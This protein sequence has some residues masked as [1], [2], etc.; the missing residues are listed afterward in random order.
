M[1]L[2]PKKIKNKHYTPC[3]SNN[4]NP[5]ICKDKDLMYVNAECGMCI[6]CR[7]KKQREWTARLCEEIRYNK[8]L[9][10]TLTFDNIHLRELGIKSNN[11]NEIAKRAIRLFL[12]RIRK[13]TKKSIKHW[14]ITELGDE[15]ERIHIHG[16]TWCEES[17]IKDNWNYGYVYIGQFVNEKTIRY[18]TKYML[19]I[20][21]T[22]KDFIPKI[23]C[24]S[25]IGKNY[26]DRL[27]ARNNEF[28]EKDT[29][30]TYRLK[31]GSKIYLPQYYRRKIYTAEERE[32]LWKQKIEK[33]ISYIM[34]EKVKSNTDEETQLRMY[35]R[36]KA[37]KLYKENWEEWE[38]KKKFRQRMKYKK[39]K[40][41]NN[42]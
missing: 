16:I 19:K 36:E 12:E 10:V 24:S 7:R 35:Y 5:P 33:G 3:K 40:D 38:R 30:E 14:F 20:K 15:T 23:M 25:G 26:I 31:N 42:T 9:F 11:D 6:E 37:K 28:K 34:G 2:Y 29:N 39:Y 18:I 41:A 1:C 4:Y 32:K 13:K 21:E 22:K 27:D 17:I 8:G